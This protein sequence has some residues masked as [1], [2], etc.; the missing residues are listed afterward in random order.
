MCFVRALY[1]YTGSSS[2]ELSFLE[3]TVFK[4][5]SKGQLGVDD[6]YWEGELAGRTGAFPSLL[7]EEVDENGSVL[8]SEE[9]STQ[10][11]QNHFTFSL[12]FPHVFLF[13]FYNF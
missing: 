13:L 10:G 11:S 3:G 4:V 9:V 1:D 12:R 5:T 6:G 8:G 7:V 2:E